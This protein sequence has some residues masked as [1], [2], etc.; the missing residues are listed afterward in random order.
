MKVAVYSAKSHYHSY[1][2]HIGR[3]APNHLHQHFNA[4]QAYQVLH[5]DIT[6]V[7][8]NEQIKGYLSPVIDEATDAVVAYATS[9]HP[10]MNLVN[11]MLAGLFSKLPQRSNPI[12]HSDQ[13][14]RYQHPLY[15]SLL[16][17]H[18]ITQSMSRKGN[19][20]DNSPAESFFNLIKRECLN[21][22]EITSF[23]QFKTVIDQYIHWYNQVRISVNKKGMTPNEYIRNHSIL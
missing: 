2:G 8:I 15:Q 12:L 5:T 21:R 10:N 16:R 20:L 1:C 9:I 7:S 14:W 17:Q 22:A 13:G 11:T 4:K 23:K 6:Q 3:T 19:C 18:G